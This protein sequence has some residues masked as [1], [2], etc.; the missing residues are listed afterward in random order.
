MEKNHEGKDGN[1]KMEMDIIGALRL[2]FLNQDKVRR[3]IE[4]RAYELFLDRGCQHGHHEED[5]LRAEQDVLAPLIRA[6]LQVAESASPAEGEPQ[7]QFLAAASKIRS[8][9]APASATR[10]TV[11]KKSSI[12][13]SP[14]AAIGSTT[15]KS[16]KSKTTTPKAKKAAER[17]T[18]EKTV[19][20]SG[21]AKGSPP[22]SPEA[23]K[24]RTRRARDAKAASSRL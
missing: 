1:F 7:A 8:A 2:Q 17:A 24:K 13:A 12:T 21:L 15:A 18:P 3:Q 23:E 11:R 19:A 9:K 10:K 22:Q 20:V 5:W 14:K 4:I 6:Q 16:G